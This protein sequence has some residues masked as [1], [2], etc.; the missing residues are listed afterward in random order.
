MSY[1][2]C[3]RCLKLTEWK[4]V[5]AYKDGDTL[6]IHERKGALVTK[7]CYIPN[8]RKEAKSDSVTLR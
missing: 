8:P 7:S 2:T 4:N 6:F 3:P 5:R 1:E